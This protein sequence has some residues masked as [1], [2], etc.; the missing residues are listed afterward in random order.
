MDGLKVYILHVM[1]MEAKNCKDASETAKKFCRVY[2]Q[3]LYTH[4]IN[5]DIYTYTCRIHFDAM[6]KDEGRLL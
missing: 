3:V 4:I 6:N 2:D 5:M 1:L